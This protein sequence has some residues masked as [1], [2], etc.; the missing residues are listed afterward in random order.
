MPRLEV[1]GVVQ[2]VYENG[3]HEK[4][5]Q[6]VYWPTLMEIS[7]GLARSTLYGRS[8]SWSKADVRALKVSSTRSGK[9]SGR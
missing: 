7:L 5:P 4:A 6:I 8:H 3:V 9:P 1:I 2:D